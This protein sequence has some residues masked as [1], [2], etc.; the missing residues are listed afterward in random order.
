MTGAFR[1][2][3]ARGLTALRRSALWWG[4]GIV[5]L[6]VVSAAFWPSLEG[7]AALEGFEDMEALMEAFGA[8]N[9][10]TPA[11]YLDGQLYALM[12]PLLLSGMAIAGLSAITSGDED[13]GRLELLHSL[14]VSR[15]A[16]W[17][18]RWAAAMLALLGVAAVTAG[19]MVVS[20]PVFSLDE[21]GAG[22]IV[23]ATFGCALL[24]AFH[25]SVAY[26]A[27]GLGGSRG[28]SAGIAVLVLVVGY[29]M[30]FLLPIADALAGVRKWSPWYWAIGE[31]P[32]S[33]GVDGLG[34]ALLA[35]VCAGVVWLGTAGV[36]RRDIR[37]A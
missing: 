32:V 22:R 37:S 25:A 28:L 29:I 34:L 1:E 26:A 3:L 35:L 4:G 20:L 15:R 9:M 12:L 14:P 31:Q 24:A 19:V 27:G 17:L 16:V 36:E 18:G 10:A 11:G 8:Q 2:V 21:V 5:A 33:N 6:A 30:D 7:S 23:D 13:A